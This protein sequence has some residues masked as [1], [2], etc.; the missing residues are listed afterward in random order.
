VRVDLV[1]ELYLLVVILDVMLAWVTPDPMR[2]P[3]RVT[4]VLTEPVQLVVRPL[5]SWLPTRGWDLSP[6]VIVGL[7]GTTRV[8]WMLP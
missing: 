6:L 3:R 1:I 2:W 4:H 5:V 7:L 8:L